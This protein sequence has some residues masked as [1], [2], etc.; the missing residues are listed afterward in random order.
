MLS[1]STGAGYFFAEYLVDATSKVLQYDGAGKLIRE[2]E[3]PGIGSSAGFSGKVN[4][5]ILY[6]SYTNYITPS[7]IYIFDR[8]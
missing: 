6:Y 4:D 5:E 7:S 3:L 8:Y 1:I 2:V